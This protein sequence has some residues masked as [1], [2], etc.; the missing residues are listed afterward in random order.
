MVSCST[1]NYY[2]LSYI[3]TVNILHI[4]QQY[5]EM[6]FHIP[7]YSGRNADLG[8]SWIHPPQLPPWLGTIYICADAVCVAGLQVKLWTWTVEKQPLEVIYFIQVISLIWVKQWIKA[9]AVSKSWKPITELE[10]QHSPALFLPCRLRR[11]CSQRNANFQKA[12]NHG[13]V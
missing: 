8:G 11:C 2:R 6:Q 13:M 1:Q 5:Q 9:T 3:M 7:I 10:K 12:W 4:S